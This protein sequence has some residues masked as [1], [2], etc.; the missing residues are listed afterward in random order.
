MLETGCYKGVKARKV[1]FIAALV[2]GL[3]F[4]VVET[5][6]EYPIAVKRIIP[7]VNHGF[8]LL[9]LGGGIYRYTMKKV[10]WFKLVVVYSVVVVAHMAWN[11]GVNL[12]FPRLIWISGSIT[13]IALVLTLWRLWRIGEIF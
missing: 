3:S 5:V 10:E 1:L 4:G 13:G 9:I 6:F 2:L 12:E 7:T 8:W 11:F